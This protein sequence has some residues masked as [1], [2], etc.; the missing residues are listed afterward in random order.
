MNSGR[1]YSLF[2]ITGRPADATHQPVADI[3]VVDTRYFQTMQVPLVVRTQFQRTRHLQDASRRGHRSDGSRTRYWPDS[4]PVGQE[5]NSVLAAVCK[6]LTIVGIA[7]DIK[8]DG[9]DSPTVPHIYVSL[10]QFAP[11]N[12]VVFLRSRNV[13]TRAARRRR[14]PTQWKASRPTFP[15]TASSPWIRL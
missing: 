2:T 12:A 15:C 11:V 13:A 1:N 8:S 4:D 10:G 5:L 3:A 9:Y 14:A 7:G 6:G